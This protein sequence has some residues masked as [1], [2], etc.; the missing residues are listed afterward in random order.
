MSGFGSYG[1]YGGF[2]PL[3]PGPFGD[4]GNDYNRDPF[5]DPYSNQNNLQDYVDRLRESYRRGTIDRYQLRDMVSQMQM[6]MGVGGGGYNGGGY[7]G[8]YGGGG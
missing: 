5:M 3:G 6:Q 8:G 4:F 7:G 2:G 1:G